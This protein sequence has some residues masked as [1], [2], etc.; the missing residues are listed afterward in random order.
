MQTNQ[1]TAVESGWWLRVFND[2]YLELY[3]D[4][5]SSVRSAREVDALAS[6]FDLRPPLRVLDA[7]CGQGRHAVALAQRGFDV[8]GVDLS[9]E[10][11]DL[12]DSQAKGLGV[13]LDLRQLDLR[14]LSFVD[15][16]DVVLSLFT[17]FGYFEAR[18]EHERL[19]ATFCRALRP[20]GRL[21]LETINRDAQ[22]LQLP[23]KHWWMT[24]R[25]TLVLERH[26]FDA[27]RGRL[28]TNRTL[29]TQESR[30]IDL[31]TSIRLFATEDI[32]E[33]LEEA[34]LTDIAVSAGL[35]EEEEGEHSRSFSPYSAQRL[36]VCVAGRKSA[37]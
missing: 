26:H 31:S 19:I 9:R 18:S 27:T 36:R 7:G 32:V 33:L 16:F 4:A 8:L 20:G 24:P 14:D 30:P 15:E 28:V 35:A 11:L 29:F 5:L 25:S 3:E 22:I 10:L 2:R 23:R 37:A 1:S 12:A 17:S 21:I 6:A 13:A 34:G